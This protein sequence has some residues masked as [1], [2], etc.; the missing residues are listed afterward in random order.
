M[1]FMLKFNYIILFTIVIGGY[2][3]TRNTPIKPDKPKSNNYNPN[4]YD[5][6]NNKF[7]TP[8]SV[9]DMIFTGGHWYPINN[10]PS[11]TQPPE[12]PQKIKWI[13][14][15]GKDFKLRDNKATEQMWIQ[16]QEQ[17]TPLT[18]DDVREIIRT[19]YD[20]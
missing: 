9:K 1:K 4:T 12:K 20:Q 19:E 16:Q 5:W 6:E 11:T 15:A 18:E 10:P 7:I 2:L 13:R 3:L 17:E 8:D 14:P